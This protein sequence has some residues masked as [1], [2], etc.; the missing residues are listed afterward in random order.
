MN[1]IWE[2]VNEEKEVCFEQ[3]DVFSPYYETASIVSEDKNGKI[4][5]AYNS[6]FRYESIFAPL[7]SEEETK[8]AWK[9]KLFDIITHI[10]AEQ[11]KKSALTR[12]EGL[13]CGIMHQLENGVYGEENQKRYLKLSAAKRHKLAGYMTEQLKTGASVSL[14]AKALMG[15]WET[16]VVYKN[17][18]KPKQLLVYAGERKNEELDNIRKLAEDIFLPLDYEVRIFW[19]THFGIWGKQETMKYKQI[20]IF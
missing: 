10:L 16:G 15:L 17:T 18:V 1:Y 6:L 11:E 13:T 12:K 2:A 7:L 9:D 14:F 4:T 8:E 5:V 20:E 3:A 19:E